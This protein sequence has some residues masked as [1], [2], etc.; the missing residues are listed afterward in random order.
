MMPYT[1][2][3]VTIVPRGSH[4]EKFHGEF[5]IFIRKF[6]YFIIYAILCHDFIFLF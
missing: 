6:R 5:A 4:G 2:N 1:A 3:C